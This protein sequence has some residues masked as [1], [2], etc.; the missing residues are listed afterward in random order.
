MW[1]H[2]VVECFLLKAVLAL[3]WVALPGIIKCSVRVCVCDGV[4]GNMSQRGFL[5]LGQFEATPKMGKNTAADITTIM[6]VANLA[7]DM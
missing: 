7:Q 1:G 3:L 6:P 5:E 4:W 2:L